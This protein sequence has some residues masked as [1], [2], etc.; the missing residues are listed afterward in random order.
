V[1]AA[2]EVASVIGKGFG[3][4]ELIGPVVVVAGDPVVGVIEVLVRVQ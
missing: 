3:F 2:G 1:P 4:G